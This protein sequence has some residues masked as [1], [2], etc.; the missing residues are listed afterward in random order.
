M[1]SAIPIHKIGVGGNHYVYCDSKE[2]L[3]GIA[4]QIRKSRNSIYFNKKYGVW[5]IRCKSK[6]HKNSLVE[7]FK[8]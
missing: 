7:L 6:K 5:V 2:L 1:N 8:R 3:F 4:D